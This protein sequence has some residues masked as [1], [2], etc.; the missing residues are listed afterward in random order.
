[1]TN[2]GVVCRLQPDVNILLETMATLELPTMESLSAA[3]A[4]EFSNAMAATRPPGPDVGEIVDG[5]LPGAAGELNYRL[6]R[7]GSDGPHP[8]VVYFHGG[9]WVLGSHESDDPFCRDMCVRAGAIF[10]SVDY[11]HAPEER[12]PAAADDAFAALN[13]VADHVDEL[14]GIPGQLAV[15]GWSA[16]GNLAAVVCQLARDAGGPN[17]VGQLLLTPVTDSDMTRPSYVEN[18]DGYILTAAL[19]KW[20]WDHYADPE[21]RTD[22][23]AAPLRAASLA[24]LPPALVVTADFDP[25]RDEGI[26]YA[27]ALAEAGVPVR[28]VAARGHIH[29][30]VTAVDVLP[31]GAAVR[32]E[33]ADA[34]REFFGARVPA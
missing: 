6:Y 25:L 17:I 4:R 22:P 9:G 11:R 32:A 15:A 23:K 30:S 12:F 31:T 13:W 34:L 18:A 16:G 19:M 29:T 10:V 28:R 21:Q 24:N 26:A 33:M 7:P 27:N 3:E 20:F 1:M 14:G 2:D 8:V 5:T